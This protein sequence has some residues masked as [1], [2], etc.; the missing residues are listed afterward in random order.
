MPAQRFR[1]ARVLNWYDKQY[2][3]EQSRMALCTERLAHA[4]KALELHRTETLA[5]RAE[6]VQASTVQAWELVSLPAFRLR[7][8]HRDTELAKICKDRER[9]LA[10][11]AA[12]TRRA[13]TRLRLIEKL[14]ERRLTELNYEAARELEN[15][16]SEVHLAA[17]ARSLNSET[18]AS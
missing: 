4:E 1:L 7:A 8:Q 18:S 3:L 9:L 13:H 2:Q 17:Y 6:V 16:A 12:A 5:Q 10:R 14:K 11:Q 15:L